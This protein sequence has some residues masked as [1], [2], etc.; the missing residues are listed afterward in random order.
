MLINEEFKKYVERTS[1]IRSLSSPSIGDFENADDYALRLHK[2]FETIGKLA[3]ENREFLNNFFYPYLD[4][5]S[6][7]ETSEINQLVSFSDSLINPEAGESLD[8]PIVSMISD[9]LISHAKDFGDL[10]QQIKQEDVQ[11]GV[12]Y[13]LMNMTL[14]LT[15]YPEISNYYRELGFK[16]GDF[17]FNVLK[18][19]NFEKIEDEE[20]R[21]IVIT[22]ARFSIAFYEGIENQAQKNQEQTEKTIALEPVI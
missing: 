14:R 9:K 12:I 6:K 20:C 11:I 8:L 1:R 13:D 15:A 4:K 19:E 3:K 2:N 5:T 10:Y 17:F 18:K 16:I 22:N 7:L 21:E